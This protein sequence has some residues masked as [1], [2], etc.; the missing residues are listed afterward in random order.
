MVPTEFILLIFFYSPREPQSQLDELIRWLYFL[1]VKRMMLT[2]FVMESEL[3]Q[4]QEYR[5]S[6]HT[7]L[8]A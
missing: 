4:G 6:Q 3:K 8:P 2:K 1:F 7:I 5:V